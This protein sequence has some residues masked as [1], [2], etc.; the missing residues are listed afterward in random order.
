MDDKDGNTD[1]RATYEFANNFEKAGV[2]LISVHSHQKQLNKS[3]DI[4]I[5]SIKE[6]INS[7]SIPVIANGGVRTKEYAELLMKEAGAT[8]VMIGQGL[9][10]SPCTET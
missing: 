3:G 1:I 8:G 5:T 4:D 7:V 9:L 6:I 10:E 2:S